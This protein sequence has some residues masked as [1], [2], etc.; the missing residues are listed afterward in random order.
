[1]CAEN[2]AIVGAGPAGANCA[3]ELAKR[4]IYPTIFDHSHPREKCCGGGIPQEVVEKFSIFRHFKPQL[5]P[6][7][8]CRL[9]S[10]LDT[11]V[12]VKGFRKGFSVSRLS[13]DEGILRKAIEKGA[14]HINEKVVG[15]KKKQLWKIKTNKRI[16]SAK[17]LVGADGVNSLVRRCDCILNTIEQISGKKICRKTIGAFAPENLA[18]TYGYYAQEVEEKSMTIK[19]LKSFP[20][21]IWI[22]PRTDNCSIGIGGEL[23]HG[24]KLKAILDNFVLPRYPKIKKIHE[25]AHMLPSA[26]DPNFFDLPCCSRD[27]I[28][29]GDAAGHVD[30]ITGAGIMYALWS[31]KLAADAIQ[32]KNLEE[33]D[34]LWRQEY[35]NHLKKLAGAEERK[36]FFD[37]ARIELSFLSMRIGEQKIRQKQETSQASLFSIR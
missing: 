7:A 5:K 2:T 10:C 26:K 3:F 36:K 12:V 33:Y 27:W 8:D 25:F 32:T 34:N 37:P 9:I 13:F 4:G 30:P 11:Q 14:K 31:G 15:I 18:L 19:F 17:N 21:Y 24:K 20:G 23:K 6:I 1:M 22:I 29:V 35:G 28:L 16:F